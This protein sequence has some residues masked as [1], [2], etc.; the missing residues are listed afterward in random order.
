MAKHPPVPPATD[1]PIVYLRTISEKRER[2][3]E[4]DFLS[5]LLDAHKAG[6]VDRAAKCVIAALPGITGSKLAQS[7]VSL[8]NYLAAELDHYPTS[9]RT[10]LCKAVD[11]GLNEFAYNAANH[12]MAAA[13]SVTAYK[14]AERYYKIAMAYDKDPAIQAAAHV[15][16]CP[17]IRDGLIS[18]TPDWPAAVE[19]YE[20]AARMGLVKAM[21]NAGNV[22]SW[23][24]YR[25][26]VNYGARAAYW[27]K[28]ALDYRA[29]GK[30]SLDMETPAQLDEVFADCM[31]VLSALNIDVKFEEAELEE[32]I[33]WAREA[34]ERGN[35]SARRNLGI[36]YIRRIMSM[37]D[38]P[39]KSPGGNW[40]AVLTHMDWKFSGRLRTE[41]VAVPVGPRKVAHMKV[42]WLT[43]ELNNGSQLPLFVTHGPCLPAFNG[44]ELMTLAAEQLADRHPDGF[45]LLSRRGYFVFRKEGSHTPIHVWKDGQLSMQALWMGSSP[46]VVLRHARDEVDFLDA[47]FST[48]TCMIPIA[49]NALDEGFVVAKDVTFEQPWVG[50][51]DQWCL[52]YVD[53]AQLLKL[54][55]LVEDDDNA[56]GGKR[57]WILD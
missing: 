22:C 35:S 43:V 51:G 25:G 18:G 55:L 38:K 41:K 21:F 3:K 47:R 15:N 17:L 14:K 49:V 19:I 7:T 28:A 26:D 23:L 9:L 5:E 8:V 31:F 39:S 24:A 45:F 2:D 29:T 42:D 40:R 13:K 11:A 37:T 33:R 4:V 6:D 56:P 12:L 30:P 57:A 20:V 54:G 50:V 52:P 32:G 27:L 53:E 48:W 36:G 46:E 10:L 34:A 44:L 1:D 16:Y